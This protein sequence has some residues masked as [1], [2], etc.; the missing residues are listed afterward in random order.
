MPK[1]VEFPN[2]W[3]IERESEHFRRYAAA[4]R[5]LERTERS[6]LYGETDSGLMRTLCRF[7]AVLMDVIHQSHTEFGTR[8]VDPF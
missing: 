5:L 2:Q 7:H 6:R 1:H 8:R 4:D 3:E